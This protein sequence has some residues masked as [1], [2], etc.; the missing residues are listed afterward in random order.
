MGPLLIIQCEFLC[1]CVH[2]CRHTTADVMSITFTAELL[3]SALL[4]LEKEI[5]LY[6]YLLLLQEEGVQ[7]CNNKKSLGRD[8]RKHFTEQSCEAETETLIVVFLVLSAT[9]N[10]GIFAQRQRR[11]TTKKTC[12][13][14]KRNLLKHS[15]KC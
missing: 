11:Q 4:C 14:T 13:N 3:L 2:M 5:T 8:C 15:D 10:I 12:L 9:I 6:H 1:V 7:F